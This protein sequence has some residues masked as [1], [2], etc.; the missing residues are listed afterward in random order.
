MRSVPLL[1]VVLLLVGCGGGLGADSQVFVVG[2][3]GGHAHQLTRSEGHGSLSWSP[4]GRKLAYISS[5]SDVARIEIADLRG[6]L[7]QVVVRLRGSFL[8]SAAW[9][10]DGRRFA[11][12][13][14]KESREVTGTLET[15]SADGSDRKRVTTFPI[16]RVLPA[17]PVWSPDGRKI[18]FARPVPFGATDQPR[19]V[20]ADRPTRPLA[21][22]AR[23]AEWDPRWSPDGRR[24]LFVR[25]PKEDGPV[26]LATLSGTGG[27]PRT[28]LSGL[29][30]VEA[31]WSPDG[32]SL[33]YISVG[34]D[35]RYHLYITDLAGNVRRL[36]GEVQTCS[37]RWSPDGSR[38]AFATYDG[39]IRTIA[40]DG[41]QQEKITRVDGAQIDELA[42]SPDGDNIAFLASH[43]PSD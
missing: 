19:I 1:L 25:E 4:D 42:W 27:V 26:A 41:S 18:A 34:D 11:F 8:T 24:I 40:P 6:K 43:P 38:I 23:A 33:A 9:S 7:D 37:P 20:V 16:V 17:G 29:P 15:V 14:M 28:L 21:R 35:Q 32:R 31:D 10:P 3:D 36:T 30:E 13:T 39:A 5:T 2:S 12:T 22:G